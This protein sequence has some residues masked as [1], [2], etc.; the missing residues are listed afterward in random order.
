MRIQCPCSLSIALCPDLSDPANGM[1]TMTGN[2]AGDTAT[3]TCD[4]G[5]QLN[6]A[7]VLNCQTDGTWDN[8]LPTC[9]YI[10]GIKIKDV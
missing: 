7:S 4:L 5:F 2:L 9:E 1:V 3:Y 10:E 6:G 8:S